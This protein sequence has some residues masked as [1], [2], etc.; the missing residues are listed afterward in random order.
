MGA[1]YNLFLNTFVLVAAI[2]WVTNR[3]LSLN[4]KV[5][6]ISNFRQR[7]RSLFSTS[8]LINFC[9]TYFPLFF[10]LFLIKTFAFDSFS[11]PSESMSPTLQVGDF[12]ITNQYQYGL[13]VPFISGKLSTG[14]VP[15]RGEIIVFS[16]P[17]TPNKYLIK[18]IIGIPG[19]VI[20][21]QD[22]LLSINGKPVEILPSNVNEPLKYPY[23]YVNEKIGDHLYT[24]I[25][26]H[27]PSLI[28]SHGD[29]I[30]PQGKYFVMGDNRDNSS[31]SRE[32][33][34]VDES[35]I[36]GKAQNIWMHMS[37]RISLPSFYRNKNL[38]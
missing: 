16:P 5:L 33:G 14:K 24:T 19:D 37:N 21:L 27:E 4:I 28:S 25:R 11:I 10:L 6:D 9:I 35:K 3:L 23:F 36:Y 32:W 12:V 30:V 13:K 2:I 7:I 38:E 17:H 15:Q 29:W 20:H 8:I 34:Y 26:S 31:D 22:Y 1:S 18:R